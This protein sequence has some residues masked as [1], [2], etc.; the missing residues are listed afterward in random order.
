MLKDY[1]QI[2]YTLPT[3]IVAPGHEHVAL[4]KEINDLKALWDVDLM[5]REGFKENHCYVPKRYA[6]ARIYD[7]FDLM[8][9]IVDE[10][11]ELIPYKDKLKTEDPTIIKVLAYLD[12][13]DLLE[14][15][16]WADAPLKPQII[17]TGYAY[18]SQLEETILSTVYS[19]SSII[20]IQSKGSTQT[21]PLE[22]YILEYDEVVALAHRISHTVQIEKRALKNIKVHVPSASYETLI[23]LIFP[24]FKLPFYLAQPK[25]LWEF[26]I[27]KEIQALFYDT[28]DSIKTIIETIYER[29]TML[30]KHPQKRRLA[31]AINDVLE[32]YW[33]SDASATHLA[34]VIE[35]EFK[36]KKITLSGAQDAIFIG[37][38]NAHSIAEEDVLFLCGLNEG[39]FPKKVSSRAII[40]DILAESIGLET[41]VER[42]I[43]ATLEA[44]TLLNH[45]NLRAVSFSHKSYTQEK[46]PSS[47]IEQN[48]KTGRLNLQYSFDTDIR[49]SYEHDLIEV[50]KRLEAALLYGQEDAT[51]TQLVQSLKKHDISLPEE[52]KHKEDTISR[53]LM[54]RLLHNKSQTSYSRMEDFFKC[55]FR[56]LIKNLLG[57]KEEKNN[58]LSRFVGSFFHEILSMLEEI[59]PESEERYAVYRQVIARLESYEDEPLNI[60]ERFYVENL[61]EHLDNFSQYVSD[62]HRDSQFKVFALERRYE[63]PLKG[64]KIT[65][66]VG[67]VDKI[68]A[69]HD[70]FAIV[71]YKSSAHEIK[72]AQLDQGLQSQL[73]FYMNVV[74]NHTP[75]LTTPI[76]LF[77]H[78]F[79]AKTYQRSE[80]KSL[81][82]QQQSD[83]KMNGYIDADQ[84]ALFDPTHTETGYIDGLKTKRTGE[85]VG[86][87]KILSSPE[88]SA[89]G[90]LIENHVN[91]AIV[92][93][94]NGRF[95]INPKGDHLSNSYS[96]KYCEFKD[97]CYRTPEDL[98]PNR[99]DDDGAFK[100]HIRG[101]IDEA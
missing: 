35:H 54:E 87:A 75:E 101:V 2:D 51:L 39:D 85:L 92:T 84:V 17:V 3:L 57:V 52:F 30:S 44:Q 36:Q 41:I 68:M 65:K 31:V 5:T 23:G 82:E 99:F 89:I 56:Y 28:D 72:L 81:Q 76:G 20:K 93:I 22:S 21:I 100:S 63:V 66:M 8:P 15:K 1:P 33:F 71:D 6:R 40:D 98:E 60:E 13:E 14:K 12:K 61:F 4:L 11:F 79:S 29:L 73:P 62:F 16:P 59:P 95:K 9:H 43:Q 25:P 91:E 55:E 38:L 24:R 42:S 10:I 34:V 18:L 97:I 45:P 86:R 94:E 78:P 77:Y 19:A 7:T 53:P 50:G 58:R 80:K 48:K 46:I 49:T 88:L 37:N 47:L 27:A 64:Q 74:Q 70:R 32:R 69:Y 83:W 96:C 90:A 67:I 26:P